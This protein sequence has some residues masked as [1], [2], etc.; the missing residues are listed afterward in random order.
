MGQLYGGRRFGTNDG[1]PLNKGVRSQF[2]AKRVNRGSPAFGR[3]AAA[4]SLGW[5]FE[6]GV[7]GAT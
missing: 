6:G 2:L 7:R 3:V 4:I 5:E 1:Y